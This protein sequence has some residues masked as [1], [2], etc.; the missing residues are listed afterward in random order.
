[1]GTIDSSPFNNRVLIIVETGYGAICRFKATRIRY[2]YQ[3]NAWTL[4]Q[5][6]HEVA[7]H[8]LRTVP[9]WDLKTAVL[10]MGLPVSGTV[11][12]KPE[13]KAMN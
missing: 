5:L 1:M 10:N 13:R 9:G 3:G 2:T 8:N 4:K 12:R 6:R 11:W 7:R